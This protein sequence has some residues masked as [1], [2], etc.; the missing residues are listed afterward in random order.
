[1]APHFLRHSAEIQTRF[2]HSDDPVPPSSPSPSIAPA[3]HSFGLS[4]L[5]CSF[6][7]LAFPKGAALRP[8]V[9]CYYPGDRLSFAAA[10]V[11]LTTRDGVG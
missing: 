6:R 8:Y 3:D 4:P 7:P 1:M 10:Y 11:H 5:H 9:S 2:A